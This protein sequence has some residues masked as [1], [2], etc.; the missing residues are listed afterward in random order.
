MLGERNAYSLPSP[1]KLNRTRLNRVSRH[2]D[3]AQCRSQMSSP[4]DRFKSE[5]SAPPPPTD[6]LSRLT[7][8]TSSLLIGALPWLDWFPPRKAKRVASTMSEHFPVLLVFKSS[9]A[10]GFLSRGSCEG[11]P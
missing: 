10:A 11:P 1:F 7:L 6:A 4:E 2:G 9:R 3:A 8:S 5:I